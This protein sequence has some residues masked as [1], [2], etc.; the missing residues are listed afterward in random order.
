LDTVWIEKNKL[1]DLPA[2]LFAFCDSLVYLS[3]S[4][5]QLT[6]LITGVLPAQNRLQTLFVVI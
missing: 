6:R 1:V 3:L 4:E 2:Q 5:N